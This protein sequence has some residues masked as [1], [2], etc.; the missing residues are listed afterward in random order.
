[1]V[2]A[3]IMRGWREN[4][5]LVLVRGMRPVLKDAADVATERI[6]TRCSV[7][8]TIPRSCGVLNAEGEAS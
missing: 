7:A 1:M 5:L 3:A 8:R 6:S 4:L 2:L